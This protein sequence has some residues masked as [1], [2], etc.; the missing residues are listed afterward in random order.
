M[1]LIAAVRNSSRTL[2]NLSLFELGSVFLPAKSSSQVELP[3]GGSLPSDSELGALGDSVPNQ[4]LYLAGLIL[5]DRL[6]QQVGKPAAKS[7][8]A[9]AIGA[10][11]PG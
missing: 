5:G 10:V 3:S 9:D 1:E 8:Y 6:V 2:V 11:R 7:S 4:P